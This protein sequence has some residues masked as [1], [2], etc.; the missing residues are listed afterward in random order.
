MFTE[1]IKSRKISSY[2]LHPK[3]YSN[4]LGIPVVA[5]RKQIQLVSVRMQ[6]RPTPGLTQWV[7]HPSSI[8]VSCG[9]GHRRGLD[10]VLLW[11]W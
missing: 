9:V 4:T 8:A 10:L 6:V 11:L 2:A 1:E 3:N 5:Q 7:K